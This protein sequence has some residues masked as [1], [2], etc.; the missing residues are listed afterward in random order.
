MQ[1]V[2]LSADLHSLLLLTT[3]ELGPS[4][5]D[6]QVGGFVYVL[7]DLSNE[8]SP[9]NSPVRLGVSPT[10]STPTGIS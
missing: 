7:V 8:L 10:A 2:Q 6:S 9:M 3:S 1:L 5:A 4:G